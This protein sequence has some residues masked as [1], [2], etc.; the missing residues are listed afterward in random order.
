[1]KYFLIEDHW[2]D[3]GGSSIWSWH[4]SIGGIA[5]CIYSI[6]E[7]LADLQYE[8]EGLDKPL[9]DEDFTIFFYDSY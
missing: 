7:F 5:N 6:R 9:N 2:Y 3:D 8:N 4:E 1:M